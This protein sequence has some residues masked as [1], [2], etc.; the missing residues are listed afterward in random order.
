MTLQWSHAHHRAE[1]K[2]GLAYSAIVLYSTI[3][4]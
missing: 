4:L 3:V 2:K 1:R